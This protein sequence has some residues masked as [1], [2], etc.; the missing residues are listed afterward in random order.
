M[1]EFRYP[2]IYKYFSVVGILFF[3]V[4]IAIGFFIIFDEAKLSVLIIFL[5]IT[6]L[7]ALLAYAAY[8]FFK[9]SDDVFKATDSGIF[10]ST[11]ENNDRLVA[12]HEVSNIKERNILLQR[13]DLINHNGVIILKIDYF[14]K[15]FDLLLDHILS[16]LNLS[17]IFS[18]KQKY[19][20][21]SWYVRGIFIIGAIAFSFAVVGSAISN[22][23]DA[24]LIF[25]GLIIFSIVGYLWEVK[26]ISIEDEYLLIASFF[27][28]KKIPYN[29][30]KD[31]ILKNE[32]DTKGN[33]S[34][35]LLLMLD[36]GK[37]I[38]INYIQDGILPLFASL[39]STWTDYKEHKNN[40]KKL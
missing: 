36:R 38:K 26:N 29:E 35:A 17:N 10:L 18:Q 24:T 15:N 31:I 7:F 27:K 32:K 20:K 25:M 1:S 28:K 9:R 30:L 5:L 11:R 21:S 8:D 13:L 33:L 39:H 6:I 23:Y 14:L 3:I 12:W 16:R 37:P 4:C 40:F 34:L 19:F 2:K 22:Q